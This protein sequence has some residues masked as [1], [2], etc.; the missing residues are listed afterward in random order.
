MLAQ[1]KGTIR[2]SVVQRTIFPLLF[3][4]FLQNE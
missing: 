1:A 4:I 3:L 2:N